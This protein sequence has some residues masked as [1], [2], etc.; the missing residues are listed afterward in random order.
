MQT[1]DDKHYDKRKAANFEL[2][3]CKLQTR[4]SSGAG[5]LIVEWTHDC[6][7]VGYWLGWVGMDLDG[8]GSFGWDLV[9]MIPPWLD[10]NEHFEWILLMIPPRMDLDGI[11]RM[12]IGTWDGFW[13]E[14]P[15]VGFGR[16]LNGLLNGFLAGIWTTSDRRLGNDS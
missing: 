12:W 2:P 13:M 16:L 10:L 5:K 3:N 11:E 9:R 1:P 6:V 14:Y 15:M 8:F 4:S 7:L